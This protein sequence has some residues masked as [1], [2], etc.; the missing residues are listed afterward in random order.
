M[1]LLVYCFLDGIK[2]GTSR[3][4]KTAARLMGEG[5]SLVMSAFTALGFS[6]LNCRPRR[7]LVSSFELP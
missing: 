3:I 7:S 1:R 2:K 6:T 5:V 4:M